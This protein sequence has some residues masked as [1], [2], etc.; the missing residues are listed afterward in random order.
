V[1]GRI[2]IRLRLTAA[3]ALVM[4]VVLTATG[5]FVYVRVASALDRTVDTGLRSRG[6]DVASLVQQ[7]NG[8]LGEGEGS[9][10][11]EV[12]ESHAQV[13]T[14]SGQVVDATPP[15][16][17]KSLLGPADL[18]RARQ[19][20]ILL[21][22]A[23]IG[24]SDEPSRVLA[25]PVETESRELIVAVATSLESRNDALEGLRAQLLVGGPLALLLASLA[26]YA[27]AAAALRPVESMRARA[28]RISGG[29][30][31][32][33][34]PVTAADD[35][36][37]RLGETLNDMLDR[38][39]SALERE[40]SFVA[41]ASH[42]L[43]T[44]LALLKAELE[45]ALRRPRSRQELEEAL[46][47]AAVETDRLSQLAEDLLVIARTERGALPLRRSS[48]RVMQLFER[49]AER[50]EP[51]TRHETR[52]VEV[53]RSVETVDG[54]VLRLQQALG[55]L[56]D[57]A[58]RHG[59]GTVRLSTLRRDRRIELHVTDEGPGF[60]HAFLE[61]AFDR[62]TRADES[63]T[64]G[65]AGLGLAIVELIA[66]AHGGDAGAANLA[67]GGADVWLSLP[68][69]ARGPEDGGRPSSHP[70]LI[71]RG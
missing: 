34:L 53:V 38:L 43:R 71:S 44:P 26:G 27:V 41:D 8:A 49:V 57:N 58:L 32:S 6:E 4:A 10:P 48:V 3:F 70:S 42:E 28:S 37:R 13:L 1:L 56:V 61:R 46:R 33:R 22:V 55:N 29:D 45:L 63:R 9:G 67:E 21:E 15:L 68:A 52:P 7:S 17:A 35:E 60:P 47:S 16:R 31:G 2:P 14:T 66:R 25:L 54:D 24:A 64:G 50:F 36:I 18:A 20:P 19:G 30:P 12:S 23:P 39:E 51:R 11:L 62:F 59:N 65:G 5:F 69:D 40:R